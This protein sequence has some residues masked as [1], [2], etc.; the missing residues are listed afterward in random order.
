MVAHVAVVAAH[1][2]TVIVFCGLLR[3]VLASDALLSLPAAYGVRR[4]AQ[5]AW[6]KG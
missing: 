1:A 4:M 6:G 2:V 5:R 3:F